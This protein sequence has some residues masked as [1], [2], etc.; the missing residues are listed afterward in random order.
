MGGLDFKNRFIVS[1]I[2]NNP[3]ENGDSY[4][5]N[6]NGSGFFIMLKQEYWDNTLLSSPNNTLPDPLPNPAGF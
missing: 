3:F 4:A 2:Y 5:K 1:G 6:Y